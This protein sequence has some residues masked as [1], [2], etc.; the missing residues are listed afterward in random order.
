[1]WSAIS[2]FTAARADSMSASLTVSGFLVLMVYRSPRRGPVYQ[3]RSV[4]LGR[5]GAGCGVHPTFALPDAGG[6]GAHR[7]LPPALA[8]ACQSS[9]NRPWARCRPRAA[10]ALLRALAV[11]VSAA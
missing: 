1:M 6:C 5:L 4:G 2:R 7:K 8:Q 9:R 10:L 3:C 11:C